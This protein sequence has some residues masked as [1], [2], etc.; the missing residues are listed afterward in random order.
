MDDRINTGNCNT[1]VCNTG[2]H[3]TGSFNTGDYNTGGCNTGDHNTGYRNIGD[4]NTGYH[5]IGYCNT[6]D[7][8]IGYRNIGD[9]N[10]GYHNTGSWNTG[11]C[12]TGYFNTTTPDRINIFDVPTL[13]TDWV[14]CKKPNF[15][16][17]DLTVW[18][19]VSKMTQ[20][21][22]DDNDGYVNTGGYLK[23]KDYKEAF[24]ES[25][26][27]AT[28]EDRK[29]IF[30]I[31]NFDADKFLE[32]SGIDVRIDNEI[33]AKKKVLIEKANE[34]IKQAEQL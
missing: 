15:I 29:R 28:E 20:Q 1:G 32:I 3:N 22:K 31:P 18:V 27:K 13:K 7:H 2:D 25:Y 34:L 12:N 14:N 6:G 19:P 24:K 30:N 9:F 11:N 16:Y 21:E 10:T 4:C 17:F 23:K 8:N 33:G 26:E 5:N